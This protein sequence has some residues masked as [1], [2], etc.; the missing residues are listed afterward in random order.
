M[1]QQVLGNLSYGRLFIIS[2]PAGTGKTTLVRLLTQSFS[3]IVESVSCT[4]RPPRAGEIDGKDY[5]FLTR[6]AFEERKKRGDFLESAEVFGHFYG[7]SREFV[8]EQRKKG[9]HIVLVIDTQGASFLKSQKIDATYIFI[10]PPDL[11]VLK[12]RLSGRKTENE[13]EREERL[14][15]ARKEM[16]CAA[17]YDYLIVNSDLKI[18]YEV[19]KSV[20]IAEEHKVLN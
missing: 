14:S 7:T 10:A 8:E 1:E 2:A 6:E 13:K 20:L 15:W 19:L 4:T 9:K 5:F 18:A 12:E 11:D 17:S 16:Q 3:C